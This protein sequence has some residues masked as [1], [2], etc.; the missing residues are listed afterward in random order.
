MLHVPYKGASVAIL[1]VLRGDV[2]VTFGLSQVLPQVREGKLT[3][4]ATTGSSRMA[5][6]PDVPTIAEQ[7]YPG[8]EVTAWYGL[9][10]PAGTPR[11]IVL[12][13][14]QVAAR[15]LQAPDIKQR[16]EAAG[17]QLIGNS[18]DEF[19]ARIKEEKAKWTE[20]VSAIGIKADE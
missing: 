15:A 7:G 11:A 20:L 8:F 9:L 13:L 17:N 12:R 3:A 4:L 6:L 2:P 18:P 14:H 19:A 16:L 1:D 10:A 5:V